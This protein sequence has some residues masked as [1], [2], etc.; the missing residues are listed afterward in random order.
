M[1]AAAIHGAI[2]EI[3]PGWEKPIQVSVGAATYPEDGEDFETL[4]RC[5]DQ[6]MLDLKRN[7]QRPVSPRP[8]LRPVPALEDSEPSPPRRVKP[9][10]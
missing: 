7:R 8:L 10:S 9:R 2:A 6:R 3:E 5:A 1:L 4:L